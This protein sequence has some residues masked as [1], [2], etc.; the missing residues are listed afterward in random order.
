MS[1]HR[2]SFSGRKAYQHLNILAGKIRNRMAGT[3]GEGRAIRYIGATFRSFG[4]R[5]RYQRFT[6][7]TYLP[8]PASIQLPT[9]G[10]VIKGFPIGLSR[11]TSKRGVRGKLYYFGEGDTRYLTTDLKGKILVLPATDFGYEWFS[12]LAEKRPEGVVL[13]ERTPDRDPIRVQL[14]PEW[15]NRGFPIIRVRYDDGLHL[16]RMVGESAQLISRCPA[17][18][19]ESCN[20]IA[21][22]KGE[23][24]PEEVIIIGAHHDSSWEGPGATDN[25]GGVALVLE[26]AR[27]F[28]KIGS[29]RTL[30]FITWGAEEFGLRGSI[31]YLRKLRSKAR[32]RI[33][34]VVN[35]DVQGV[36][37]GRNGAY[38]IGP[39]ELT[40]SVRL[41]AKEKGPPFDVKEGIY[42][43]DGM[44]FATKGI[45]SVNFGRGGG[46]TAYIHTDRDTIDHLSIDALENQGRFIETWLYRYVAQANVFPFAREIPERIKKKVT[47]Y[48]EKRLGVRV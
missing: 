45:P 12:H 20:V 34:L 30:R 48:F 23:D 41:L 28:K 40:A 2:P 21:E 44:P 9:R 42:S 15:P 18:R 26:L 46:S 10:V 5:V 19:A 6:I 7:T 3:R 24:F 17:R 38:I 29:R 47:E 4:Y 31:A 16:T 1:V 43:S 36:L 13:I 8:Y 35:I 14:E 32:D 25:G 33:R 39:E 11:S 22:L 27:I 37:I